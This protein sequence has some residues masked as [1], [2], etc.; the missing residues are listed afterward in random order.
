MNS[1]HETDTA[2]LPMHAK[3]LDSFHFSHIINMRKGK[4]LRKHR[5]HGKNSSPGFVKAVH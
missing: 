1:F 2:I 5:L 3:L 4:V